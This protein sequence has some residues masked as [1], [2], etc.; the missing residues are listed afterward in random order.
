M[1]GYDFDK[2]IYKGDS[3]TDFFFFIILRRPYLLIF[4]LWFLIVLALYGMK[5][6]NKKRTKQCLFFFI[7]WHHNIEKLVDKFWSKNANKIQN[8]Y[9]TQKKDDDIIISAS[10][11]F[12]IKPAIEMLNIKNWIATN[13]NTKNG[14]IYGE[15]CY[16]Q[17]KAVEFQ[18]LYPKTTLDAFYSDS[19][20]DQP[21]F[22]LSNEA[23][24]VEGEKLT[25][26]K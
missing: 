23:Y 24:L 22:D 13:F 17:A 9:T 1:T 14:K 18:R 10:L 16:G 7:P 15:N 3:S 8:W 6:L 20:S 21:M 25:K 19:Y 4:T 26:I 2:T 11:N 5:I 12:I